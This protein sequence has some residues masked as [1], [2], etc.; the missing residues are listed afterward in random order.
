[1]NK[2][3]ELFIKYREI[4]T[5][6]FVGGTTTIVSIATFYLFTYP[7]QLD[8]MTSTILSWIIA[9]IYAYITN[10]M[11]VF[12]TKTKSVKEIS[13]EFTSFVGC[14]ILTLFIEMF[15]MWLLVSVIR[16]DKGMSKIVVQFII[17]I[18]NYVFSKILVFRKK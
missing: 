16:I 8:Y 12:Q 1:M 13:K 18:L 17:F 15:I 4:I 7:L 11:V 14:R 5:Y 9:V 2:I 3:K 6:I 10:K